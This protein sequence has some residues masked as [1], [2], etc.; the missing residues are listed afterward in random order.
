MLG[1]AHE[2]NE[3]T[4]DESDERSLAHRGAERVDLAVAQREPCV[5]SVCSEARHP[6]DCSEALNNISGDI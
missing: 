2:L 4:R 3:E 5:A 1:K 6:Q